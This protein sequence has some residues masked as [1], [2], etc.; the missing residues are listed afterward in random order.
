MLSGVMYT[1]YIKRFTLDL[2][3][4]ILKEYRAFEY[5]W[6]LPSLL[7]TRSFI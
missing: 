3:N 6:H 5:S 7:I 2:Q 1:Q 4:V